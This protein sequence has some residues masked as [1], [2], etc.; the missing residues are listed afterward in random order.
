M[1]LELPGAEHRV[2]LHGAAD[3]S[4]LHVID[5]GI[6]AARDERVYRLVY[7][8]DVLEVGAD[9]ELL[10]RFPAELELL[11][12][13]RSLE[14]HPLPVAFLVG[15][16]RLEAPL[17]GAHDDSVVAPPPLCARTNEGNLSFFVYFVFRH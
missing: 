13:R 15:I 14:R 1:G 8:P 6:G 2:A 16:H 4:V 12:H 5:A 9:A 7:H 17:D 11:P 10:E 3:V